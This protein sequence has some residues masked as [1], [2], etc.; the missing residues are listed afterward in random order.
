MAAVDGV[1]VLFVGPLDLTT[2]LGIQGQFEHPQFQ[3]ALRKV[4][5]AARNAGKA[6]GILATAPDQIA[7]LRKAGYTVLAYGS[8]GGAVSTGLRQFA[9]SLRAETNRN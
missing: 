3:E 8:D 4:S 1:D 2:N 5:D 7:P 9:Q 6:A